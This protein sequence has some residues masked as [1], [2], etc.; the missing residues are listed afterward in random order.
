MNTT[1]H[2]YGEPWRIITIGQ[3]SIGTRDCEFAGNEL[4]TTQRAI[5]CVNA[6]AGIS[7]PA[8]AIQSA[9]DALEQVSQHLRKEHGAIER[10]QDASW[11]DQN[12]VKCHLNFR[13]VRL[14][15]KA[16]ELLTPKP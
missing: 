6:L 9:K 4:R 10:F 1:T 7:D 5:D 3:G 12:P 2:D 15:L 16:L 11:L 13:T 14:M 8:A